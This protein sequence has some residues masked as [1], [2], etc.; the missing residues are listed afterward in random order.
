MLP[1]QIDA[2]TAQVTRL[3]IRIEELIAAIPE[4]QGADPG[5][6]AGRSPDGF[7]AP[8]AAS[9]RPAQ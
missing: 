3:T 6:T 2:L 9:D 1:S 4:A 5:A 8:G 7:P